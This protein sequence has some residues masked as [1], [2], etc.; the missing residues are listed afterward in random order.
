ML[1]QRLINPAVGPL[2][3]TAKK[4]FAKT[5]TNPP[6]NPKRS[7][8]V[9]TARFDSPSFAPGIGISGSI[10]S[11]IEST[12]ANADSIAPAANRKWSNLV[13]VFKLSHHRIKVIVFAL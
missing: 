7:A 3:I 8:A 4:L 12:A 5:V 13:F 6:Q 11:S 9:I 2:D 10:P 1:P